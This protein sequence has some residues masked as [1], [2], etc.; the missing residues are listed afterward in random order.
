M[1]GAYK[2][3]DIFQEIQTGIPPFGYA[4]GSFGGSAIQMSPFDKLVFHFFVGSTSPDT[5]LRAWFNFGSVST[6]LTSQGSQMGP[7][8]CSTSANSL[9]F[10][11]VAELRAEYMANLN[12]NLL[13][14][15]PVISIV[16]GSINIGVACFGYVGGYGPASYYDVPSY[17]VNAEYLYF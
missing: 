15:Q 5:V 4:A 12:S 16:S 9:G 1:F 17:Y 3:R 7:I 14:V 8:T 13:W 2:F 6:T 11:I 10:M